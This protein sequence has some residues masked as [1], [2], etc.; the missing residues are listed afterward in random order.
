M[1]LEQYAAI[2]EIIGVILVIASLVYVAQQLRQN[3]EMARI[4]GSEQWVQRDFDLTGPIL[5]NRELAEV[6]AKGDRQF[7]TLDE[8]DKW[9]MLFFERRAI[10]WWHHV[11][12]LRQQ[13]LYREAD[14][15]GLKGIIRTV[16][17]RQSVRESWSVFKDSFEKPFGDFLEEQFAIVDS[18][19]AR[20]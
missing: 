13:G 12:Q 7:D 8:P 3:T 2:A 1:T 14:W 20:D 5:E 9:R 18:G 17:R 6:W 19:V 4:A 16:G 10:V 15:Q 11:Y